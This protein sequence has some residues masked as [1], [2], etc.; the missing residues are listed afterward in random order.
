MI[1]KKKITILLLVFLLF[2]VI[3]ILTVLLMGKNEEKLDEGIVA[4]KKGDFDTAVQILSPLANQGNNIAERTLAYMYAYG[5]GLP[6]NRRRALALLIRANGDDISST[7]Y[8]FAENFDFGDDVLEDDTEAIWW[9][10]KAAEYGNEKAQALLVQAYREG[11][12]GLPVNVE[13]SHYW[14]EKLE[15]K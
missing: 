7:C 1:K 12:Y 11:L 10:I 14:S 4:F 8:Y 9:Y 6:Q 15:K 5:L 3:L 13:E 2:L